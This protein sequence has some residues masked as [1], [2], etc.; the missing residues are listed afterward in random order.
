MEQPVAD[1]LG[2]VSHADDVAIAPF[3]HGID[4]PPQP[5]AELRRVLPSRILADLT[6]IV[7]FGRDAARDAIAQRAQ[8]RFERDQADR[9]ASRERQPPEP[10]DAIA[11]RARHV[12]GGAST[13][14]Q[15]ERSGEQQRDRHQMRA[16]AQVADDAWIDPGQ[17]SM[18]DELDH[19]RARG[20]RVRDD[21]GGGGGAARQQLDSRAITPADLIGGARSRSD[22][23]G[24]RRRPTHG[25][26]ECD[27]IVV[28]RDDLRHDLRAFDV[29]SLGG[30][31]L[32]GAAGTLRQIQ[33]ISR[34]IRPVTDDERGDD[35]RADRQ[36]QREPAH[37]T[38]QRVGLH[39][40]WHG[41]A[42]CPCCHLGRAPALDRNCL[43]KKRASVRGHPPSIELPPLDSNC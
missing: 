30:G 34:D 4:A 32:R 25:C 2:H 9:D 17:R 31:G 21:D 33:A 19:A 35:Q 28:S 43:K 22:F 38:V 24:Q 36:N 16:G 41:Q 40:R 15:H 11:G 8:P 37:E 39:R 5:A 10:D 18:A 20:Y 14:R 1:G 6:E 7:A 3:V 13:P 23:D 29:E 42:A 27:H 12:Q 26:L